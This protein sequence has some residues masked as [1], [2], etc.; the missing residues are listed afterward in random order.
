MAFLLD[1]LNDLNN[2][3]V[4]Q[5]V[6]FAHFLRLMFNGGSPNQSILELLQYRPM[7][8]VTEVL[9][10]A[11]AKTNQTK[12]VSHSPI[13]LSHWCQICLTWALEMNALWYCL[14]GSWRVIVQKPLDKFTTEFAEWTPNFNYYL[15]KSS[16]FDPGK[17]SRLFG[18]WIWQS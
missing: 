4:V 17:N 7:N 15:E 12:L 11:P 14:V 9:N 8:L 13:F 5:D 2:V 6:V 16:H 1:F 18:A 3:L 10:A